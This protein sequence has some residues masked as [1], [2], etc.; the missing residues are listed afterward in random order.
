M[1]APKKVGKCQTQKKECIFLK[2]VRTVPALSEN[3][4]KKKER[5]KQRYGRTDEKCVLAKWF[6]RGKERGRERGRPFFLNGTF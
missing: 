1:Y 6:A 5:K 2:V 3:I 4:K